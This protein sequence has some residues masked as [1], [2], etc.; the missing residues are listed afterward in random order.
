MFSNGDDSG[1]FIATKRAKDGLP[2]TVVNLSMLETVSYRRLRRNFLKPM[3]LL[4][5]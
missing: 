5:Y 2:A 3:T 4:I 1:Q